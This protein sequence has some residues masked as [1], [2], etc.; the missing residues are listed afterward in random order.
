MHG[1]S[2]LGG[3]GG[4]GGSYSSNG[5][6]KSFSVTYIHVSKVCK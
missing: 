4:G 1:I 2:M 6:P 5:L 3:G